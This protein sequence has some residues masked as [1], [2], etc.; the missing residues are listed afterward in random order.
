MVSML[1]EKEYRTVVVI[2]NDECI[3][4]WGLA[5]AIHNLVVSYV[6]KSTGISV[7]DCT[8]TLKSSLIK[9]YFNNA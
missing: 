1:S 8:N 2:D 3:G 9:Y 4:S 5:S 6:H 7:S